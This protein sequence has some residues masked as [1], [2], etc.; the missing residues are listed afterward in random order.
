MK[1]Q[2]KSG[3]IGYV[4]RGKGPVVLLIHAFP[5]NNSMWTPQL[6]A[7]SSRF[8]VI[9]PD[10]RGFGES[11]PPSPWSMEDMGPRYERLRTGIIAFKANIVE[12]RVKFKLGQDERDD[13]FPEILH[14]LE[15]DGHAALIAMMRDFNSQRGSAA[16]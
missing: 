3:A 5:L 8:R 11:Q 1:L 13:T 2:L 9:A 10:I 14:G 7:L 4:D 16:P 12:R 15:Q 6:A